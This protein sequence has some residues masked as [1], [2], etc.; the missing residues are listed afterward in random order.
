MSI[1]E[2]L[3]KS[4]LH[5]SKMLIFEIIHDHNIECIKLLQKYDTSFDILD[6]NGITPLEHIMM[7]VSAYDNNTLHN[8]DNNEDDKDNKHDGKDD[9]K[10]DRNDKETLYETMRLLVKYN[11]SRHPKYFDIANNLHIYKLTISNKYENELHEN[12]KEL[13]DNII[14]INSQIVKYF[15]KN[16]IVNELVKFLKVHSKF[17]NDKLIYDD[18]SNAHQLHLISN[19]DEYL[20]LNEDKIIFYM[21]NKMYDK[22][23]QQKET[24]TFSKLLNYFSETYDVEGL[25][26]I[27]EYI[28]NKYLNGKMS[29]NQSLLYYI[30]SRNIKETDLLN[31]TKF[32]TI[33]IHYNHDLISEQDESGNNLLFISCKNILLI[34]ILINIECDVN[35]CNNDGNNYLHYIIE[36]GKSNVLNKVLMYDVIR[37]YNMLEKVNN[38]NETPLLLACKLKKSDMCNILLKNGSN[39]DVKDIE[40]NTIY[41]Y[42]SLYRLDIG[43]IY[44]MEKFDNTT[45]NIVN[46]NGYK[47]VDYYMMSFYS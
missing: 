2:N 1:F 7:D 17:I 16:N 32:I 10:G 33:I 25:I 37:Q 40:G 31:I 35:H 47:P 30:C 23:L 45:E 19:I 43:N 9:N 20:P 6:N 3:I 46:N 18:I 42:I 26:F 27:I 15:I 5:P 14:G 8:K 11:Y 21:K 4:Q 13:K 41:H 38:K 22:I 12:L 28:D 24:F 39:L 44:I 36:N 29:N 34:D